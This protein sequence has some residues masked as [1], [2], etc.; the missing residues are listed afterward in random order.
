M[1]VDAETP[2][3]APVPD[4]RKPVDWWR[5][6]RITAGLLVA[7]ALLGLV[8]LASLSVGSTSIPF[9][10]VWQALWSFDHSDEHIIVRD[11]RLPRTVLGLVV[12]AALGVGGALIQAMTRNPLADP[13]ILGVNAGAAF[14]VALAVGVLG[15]TD[16]RVY[17][18]FA[19]I[20]AILVMVLVYAL[21]S[22]GRGGA[23]PI[24][25]TL[26]GVAVG[27]VLTGVTSGL[28]LLD[29]AAFATMRSWNAGSIAGR[30]FDVTSSV[31]PFIV[32]GLVLTVLIARPLNAVALGDDLARSLGADV[33]RTRLIGVVAV[34]LLCGAATAAA[35]PIVFLGLMV[36]HVARWIVGPDQR[37]ILAYTAVGAPTLL[38][39]S[40]IVGRLVVRPG[41]LQVGIVSALIG[42]PVL[43]LLVR[44][45]KASGL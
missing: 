41:E 36:P 44:R 39:V 37:W 4:V 1:T 21:G 12:G 28:V 33:N 13:G 26:S 43:I 32:I 22:S 29:P 17:V 14:F 5:V 16:I 24:R 23:T 38:L 7:V 19:F 15:F 35:G 34:T 25:L 10:T 20:G 3:A 6:G 40:D 9:S 27:A 11:M 30:G 31:L 2:R 42:A 45:G 18:W 8:F